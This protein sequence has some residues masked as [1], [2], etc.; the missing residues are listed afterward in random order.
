M[1]ATGNRRHTPPEHKQLMVVMASYKTSK[2]IAEITNTSE[3]TVQRVIN[4]WRTTGQYVHIPLE[5][6]RPRIL[7]ALDVSVGV[8]LSA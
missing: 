6:G 8:V 7:T 2:E 5:L 4:K 3:R 1:P